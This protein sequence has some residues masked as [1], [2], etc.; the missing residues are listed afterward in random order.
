MICKST[1]REIQIR[2]QRINKHNRKFDCSQNRFLTL[3]KL[4]ALMLLHF[5]AQV[6]FIHRSMTKPPSSLSGTGRHLFQPL[7][8]WLPC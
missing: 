2:T 3:L 7:K 6:L 4:G 5:A 1:Q 8:A